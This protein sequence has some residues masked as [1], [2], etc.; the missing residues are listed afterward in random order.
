MIEIAIFFPILCGAVIVF[1][2]I[3]IVGSIVGSHLDN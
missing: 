2:I 3:N 1:A